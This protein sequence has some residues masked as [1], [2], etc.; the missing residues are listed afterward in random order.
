MHKSVFREEFHLRKEEGGPVRH[1]VSARRVQSV[2]K[3]GCHGRAD[4]AEGEGQ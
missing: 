3:L 1:R 2:T 4:G